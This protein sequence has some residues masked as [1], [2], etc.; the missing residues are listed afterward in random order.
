M[1]TAAE[2]GGGVVA[3]HRPHAPV[4]GRY[5]GRVA[6]VTGGASGI[7]AAVVR[8]LHAEGATV[9]VGDRDEKAL[10]VLAA[11]LGEQ[12]LPVPVDVTDEDQVAAL[13]AVA[14]SVGGRLDVAV[15]SA[16]VGGAGAI[17][18]QTLTDWGQVLGV[19]LTG[20][21]LAMKHEARQMVAQGGGGAIVNVASLNSRVPMIGGSAYCAAKAGVAM[22][23]QCGAVELG[24]H[25]VRV[26]T[27]S[28]GLTDT[29]LTREVLA[30][31]DARA[32]YLDRIPLRAVAS[33]EEVAAAVA[34]LG[35]PDA[36]YVSGGEL[37][38]DGAWAT[39]GYP[40][41]R[42]FLSAL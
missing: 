9:A 22:L 4:P 12:V 29:P 18:E 26:N 16:G 30:L 27:V 35:S 40:D 23:S 32:A 6:V 19:C 5:E 15:N 2:A 24:E 28:P 17:T 1:S 7:G 34:F 3:R 41:L 37:V 33:P 25:R 42:P 10:E 31:P 8:R 21:M 13:V 39:T 20:V 11:E 14:V 38:V 36:A